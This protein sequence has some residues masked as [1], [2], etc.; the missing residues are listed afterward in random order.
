MIE[1]VQVSIVGHSFRLQST[2]ERVIDYV[3]V[4]LALSR[5][6]WRLV[7]THLVFF[8]KINFI[9]LISSSKCHTHIAN[10]LVNFTTTLKTHL[11]IFSLKLNM[12]SLQ[13]I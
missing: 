9:K 5:D 13:E 1:H 7:E 2:M 12:Y 4:F 6:I 8:I 11:M 10:L 3:A